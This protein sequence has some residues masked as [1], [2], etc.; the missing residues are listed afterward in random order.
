MTA[1]NQKQLRIEI[2]GVDY[3]EHLSFPFVL[4]D[5]GNE[6]LKTAIVTLSN[7]PTDAKFPPFTAVNLCGGKYE[8]VIANDSVKEV[9]GRK[10][11]NHELTLIDSTKATERVL[12][13]AKAFTQPLVL[14]YLANQQKASCFQAIIVN[15]EG[16][17]DIGIDELMNYEITNN[18]F[19][20]PSQAPTI[21]ESYRA[22]AI[23]EFCNDKRTAQS[24]KIN[25]SVYYSPNTIITPDIAKNETPL[26][27]KALANP[28]EYFYLDDS[29]IS[30]SGIYTF[31]YDAVYRYTTT[32]QNRIVFVIPISFVNARKIKKPY[33]LYE[34]L[35]ILLETAEPLRRG[36]DVPRY[37]LNLTQ[38]QEKQFKA[39]SAPELHFSNGRSLFENLAEIG[40]FIHCVPRVDNSFRVSF[41]DLGAT[42]YADLSKAQ[43][44][45]RSEQFNAADYASTLESN[46]ANLI[47]TDDE[48][49]GSVTEPYTDGFITLRSADVG[50]KE[51]TSFIPTRFP[52]AKI[53]SVKLRWHGDTTKTA[54]ITKYIFEQSEYDMLSNFS[55]IYP[56]SKTYAL[57]YSM[58]SKNIDGLWYRVEDASF[59]L[60]NSFKKYAIENIVEEALGVSISSVKQLYLNLSF[61][62]TYIPIINGRARQERVETVKNGKF[63]IAHNQS[64]NKMSARAFGE[65]LRGKIAM[66]ANASES[67]M[68]MFKSLS[69]VPRAGLLYDDTSYIS[70]VTTRVFPHFCIAQIDLSENFNDLGAYV[71]LKNDIRQYEIPQGE[72]RLTLLEEYCVIG[73]AEVSDTDTICRNPMKFDVIGSFEANETPVDVSAVLA[74]TFDEDMKKISDVFTL[75]VYSTAVG[76]SVYFGFAFDDN[77]SVGVKSVPLSNV[78][79]RGIEHVNYG[80]PLFAE[81]KY[82]NFSLVTKCKDKSGVTPLDVSNSLPSGVSVAG[83]ESLATTAGAPIVWNKDSADIGNVA[84]QLHFVTNDGYVIG[85][86]LAKMMSFIRTSGGNS[87]RAKCY[88]YDHRINAITGDSGESIEDGCVAICD[89]ELTALANKPEFSIRILYPPY[90][91]YQSWVIKRSDNKCIIGKNAKTIPEKI[92]FNFKR[93]R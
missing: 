28:Q 2:G 46:F 32:S 17:Y 93:K 74:Q 55:G 52:I 29:V 27:S 42:E 40:K 75:P 9:F 64:A 53:K 67:L 73:N 33:T 91:Q 48:T 92:Y 26:F 71:E 8:Y 35:E 57:Y 82:L 60:L 12:M 22:F 81:A 45:G 36:L 19:V 85:S 25:V 44:F 62:V 68:Y 49:E 15:D 31:I 6:Q 70:N 41:K 86:E 63:V 72:T 59:T 7:M 79:Y 43:K 76:N 80:D 4:Q 24:Y 23:D 66:M 65:N 38:E 3:S 1:T 16:A 69:D 39:M 34:V 84:Y 21:G 14:D 30:E 5:T 10:R 77:F 47:N 58:G 87:E 51:N 37:T 11:W 89:I 13:E 88:F 50:I 83:D 56:F 18:T 61:Q 90:F 54:D 20:T 78:L